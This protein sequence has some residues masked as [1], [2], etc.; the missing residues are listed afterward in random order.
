MAQSDGWVL[1]LILDFGSGHGLRVVGS[2]SA[3]GSAL[4]EESAWDSLSP[5][6]PAARALSL[7][8]K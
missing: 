3:L 4:S 1:S 6:A 5:S 2:S 8:N 7:S